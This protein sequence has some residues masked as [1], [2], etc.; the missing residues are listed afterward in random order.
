MFSESYLSKVVL[1]I[2]AFLAIILFIKPSKGMF[3]MK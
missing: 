3:A 2:L 1:I